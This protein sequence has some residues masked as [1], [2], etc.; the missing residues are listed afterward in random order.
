MPLSLSVVGS[1]CAA[2]SAFNDADTQI[3]IDVIGSGYLQRCVAQGLYSADL[4]HAPSVVQRHATSTGTLLL[5]AC[6]CSEMLPPPATVQLVEQILPYSL[7]AL[8]TPAVLLGLRQLDDGMMCSLACLA[9]H[10]S[11]ADA[12]DFHMAWWR[13]GW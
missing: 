8:N 6:L 2:L 13:R 11:L 7:A 10:P 3:L 5:A 1:L 4:P 9:W 12:P